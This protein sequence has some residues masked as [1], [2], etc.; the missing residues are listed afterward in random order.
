[1]IGG[2]GVYDAPVS[3]FTM[4]R[5]WRSR[6]GAFA[7]KF[8]ELLDYL[9]PPPGLVVPL[10]VPIVLQEGATMPS[11]AL[12]RGCGRRYAFDLAR[13]QL[14]SGLRLDA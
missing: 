5:F 10:N 1:M 6:C 8:S 3:A 9:W 4:A 14:G 11:G 13:R 2:F 7:A 12:A